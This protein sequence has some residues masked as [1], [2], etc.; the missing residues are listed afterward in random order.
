MLPGADTHAYVASREVYLKFE[1]NGRLMNY[2]SVGVN[3]H[4]NNLGK[5]GEISIGIL[6]SF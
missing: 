6:R 4:R 3:G 5:F 1:H 2:E